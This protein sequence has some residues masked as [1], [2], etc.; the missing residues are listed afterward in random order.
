MSRVGERSD[1]WGG[2][3]KSAERVVI[4][5]GSTAAGLGALGFGVK[6]MSSFLSICE[7]KVM[8]NK[9]R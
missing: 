4:E 2:V 1:R 9:L 3:D 6:F 8:P 7:A 5:A